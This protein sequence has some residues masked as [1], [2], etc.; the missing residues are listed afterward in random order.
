M[1]NDE[2]TSFYAFSL[3]KRESGTGRQTSGR[4]GQQTKGEKPFN[5]KDS[6]DFE[7]PLKKKVCV[8]HYY[9]I[10]QI[11]KHLTIL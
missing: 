9:T 6:T 2:T 7:F 4:R 1:A 8:S 5:R 10:N 11:T 3:V